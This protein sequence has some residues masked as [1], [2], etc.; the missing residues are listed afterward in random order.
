MEAQNELKWVTE[1][2]A[3]DGYRLRLTFN[4][5]SHR[6]FDCQPLIERYRLF[7]PLR[8]ED[9]FRQFSLDGWTVTWLN[10][11]IDIAPE[12]LYEESITA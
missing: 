2:C 10:G 12:H 11:S 6:I 7:A 3:M 1:A 8:K 9:V 5:G 4:D